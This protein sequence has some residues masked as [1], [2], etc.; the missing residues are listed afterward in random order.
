MGNFLEISFDKF[1]FRVAADRYYNTEGIWSQNEKG[2]VRLGLSDYLQ[3]RSGDIAFVELP[4]VGD[5]VKGG[6]AFVNIE[7][8][9]VDISL[10]CPNSGT[11]TAINTS[12]ENAPEIINQDPYGRGWLV[13]LEPENWQ[14]D[15]DHLLD[16]PSYL[17]MIR[18]QIDEERS[19]T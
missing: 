4:S 19:R 13:L 16:A 3:Q 2:L 17:E 10:A 8:I 12:L 9:K 6:D 15:R 5:F 7:T 1:T 11:V 14:A 18:A